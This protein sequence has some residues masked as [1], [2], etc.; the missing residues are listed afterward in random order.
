M[1]RRYWLRKDEAKDMAR[2]A[3]KFGGDVSRLLKKGAELLELTDGRAIVLAGGKGLF[4]KT[5]DGLIPT[6]HAAGS[7][8]IRRVVIDMGAV[9]AVAKGADVM[10]PGV[11]S[12]DAEIR[13]G[14][15]VT[16]VDE[17]HGKPISIG[18]ALIP[19]TEMR[20]PEGKVVR[21]V[22]HV[23]DEVWRVLQEKVKYRT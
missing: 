3:E 11:L 20:R 14:E 22:H 2:E 1:K 4:I 13:V 10:G 15:P 5:P 17:R 21:N 6:L 12:A 9:P 18:V 23:G 8:Q 7:L 16:V 19:G